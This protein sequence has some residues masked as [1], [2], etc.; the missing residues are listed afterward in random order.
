MAEQVRLGA[1]IDQI[2]ALLAA[3]GDDD[4]LEGLAPDFGRYDGL[5]AKIALQADGRTAT[6]LAPIEYH[7]PDGSDWPVPEGATL[8]GASIP[9]LFWTLIGGPFEGKYRDASIVHDHFCV[10]HARSW[11]QTHRMFHDAMRCSGVSRAK[12]GVMFYAVYRFGPR[13]PAQGLEGLGGVESPPLGAAD[14]EAFLR[15]AE[16]IVTHGLD[17]SEIV[18]LA[19]ARATPLTTPLEA[20]GE[21]SAQLLVVAGGSASAEDVAAVIARANALPAY[22][23]EHFIDRRIRIVACRE[24]VTDFERDLRGVVPR[25]WER[26]GRTWDSVPGSYFDD[27]KRV[28]I[29]T[30]ASPGDGARVVPDKSSGRHG[31]DDLVV[32]ESLHGYDYSLRHTLLA[33]AG[34]VAAR[35]ADLGGLS[36]YE[37]Q[38]GQAGL[39]ETFAETGA[40][41]CANPPG[42]AQRCPN[43]AT[44]WQA[45]PVSTEGFAGP[46]EALGEAEPLGAATREVDGRIVLDLRA[47]DGKGAIGHA[48]LDIAPEDPAHAVLDRDLFPDSVLEGISKQTQ[49]RTVAFYR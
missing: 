34:F 16:A 5:P 22:V 2:A 11:E 14:A 35:D 3:E 6:L 48:W 37:R 33:D 46:L 45:M 29:A 9:R 21:A 40:Q 25:G 15:D 7:R 23:I 30:I 32:H 1:A 24:A 47:T 36:D 38:Q 41:H 4:A 26:T 8:D 20:V 28:V 44:F 17:V 43:L 27:R 12:A 19:E 13:W 39:E 42:L 31:S 18:A 49:P 10:T